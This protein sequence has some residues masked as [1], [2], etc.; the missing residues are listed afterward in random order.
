MTENKS[1]ATYITAH[2]LELR[3]EASGTF[4]DRKGAIADHIRKEG[5][6]SDWKI[7]ENVITFFDRN[8]EFQKCNAVVSYKNVAYAV[9]DPDTRNFFQQKAM[10]FWNN[11]LKIKEYSLPKI[12]RFGVRTKCFFS[13][14][15]PFEDINS[16][17]Y[18]AFF[19][20]KTEKI[21]GGKEV[22]LQ[23][24]LELKELDYFV[25]IRLGPIQKNE[26]GRYFQIK[27]DVFKKA[28]IY[29]DI[30]FY[31]EGKIDNLKINSLLNKAM[32][33]TWGKIDRILA[34]MDMV[35]HV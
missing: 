4:L 30:D 33:L 13:S 6:F 22:D 16:K 31:Q 7:E 25:K 11:V 28:G 18:K 21:V 23:I 12:S 17:M 24:I 2:I 3:H 8:A 27:K 20:E 26:A 5:L 32:E 15:L 10:S 9:N 19:S 29:L 34:E 35:K 14:D 1:E